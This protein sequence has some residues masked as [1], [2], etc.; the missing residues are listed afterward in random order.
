MSVSVRACWSARRVGG[1]RRARRRPCSCAGRRGRCCTRRPRRVVAVGAGVAV[2][3]RVAVLVGAGVDVL[4]AARPALRPPAS[5]C[6]PR[7]ACV[8]GRAGL[9]AGRGGRGRC[10]R[11]RG[12]PGRPED[13]LAVA[14]GADVGGLVGVAVGCGACEPGRARAR[15]SSR[16]TRVDR[17]PTCVVRV[18]N[19]EKRTTKEMTAKT[20]T[21]T[22]SRR[23]RNRKIV[24][25]GIFCMRFDFRLIQ[26]GWRALFHPG[27]PERRAR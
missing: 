10:R 5:C 27:R 1:C 6:R 23:K 12:R 17:A 26:S 9:R 15:C 22:M 3:G 13:G 21:A 8:C 25:W 18:W 16:C 11:T 19:C 24:S 4:A 2:G 20:T 7:W 14:V